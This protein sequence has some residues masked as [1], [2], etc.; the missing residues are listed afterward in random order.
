MRH[1]LLIVSPSRINSGMV[2]T[3]GLSSHLIAQSFHRFS[4]YINVR[5]PKI[6]RF[7]SLSDEELVDLEFAHSTIERIHRRGVDYRS[8]E[9]CDGR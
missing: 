8:E 4:P 9:K 2:L 3:Y 7:F 1:V 6:V 5:S